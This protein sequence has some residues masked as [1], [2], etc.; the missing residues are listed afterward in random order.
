[1][2]LVYLIKKLKHIN[3]TSCTKQYCEQSC[4]LITQCFD[5]ISKN[6]KQARAARNLP[7]RRRHQ[8]SLRHAPL[9]PERVPGSQS[10]N[11]GAL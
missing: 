11:D 3:P 8:K 9:G 4:K 5:R 2:I 7:Q 10:R 1:M 6:K